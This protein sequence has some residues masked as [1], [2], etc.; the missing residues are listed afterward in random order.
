VQTLAPT[1]GLYI[2]IHY[3]SADTT[4]KRKSTQTYTQLWNTE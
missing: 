2:I 1:L 4:I 3:I